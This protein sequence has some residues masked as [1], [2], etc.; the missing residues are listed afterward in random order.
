MKKVPLYWAAQLLGGILAGG[1][2]LLIFTAAIA[3][4]E[5]QQGLTRGHSSSIKSAAAFGDYWSL[6]P[7]VAGPFHAV[8]IEAFGTAFLTFVIF[9]I[10]HPKNE[11]V[12]SSAVAPMVGTAIGV[13]IALLG[14]LTGAGINPARDLGPRIVTSMAGWGSAAFT[15]FGAYIVGPLIGGPIGAF[16]ADYILFMD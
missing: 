5:E 11:S 6:S 4:F 1:I 3:D 16:I 15:N 12:A 13:M 7:G 8:F 2:N 9:A 10:T 14:S